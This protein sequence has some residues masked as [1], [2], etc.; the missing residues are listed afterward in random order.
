MGTKYNAGPFT[1]QARVYTNTFAPVANVTLYWTSTINGT[2]TQNSLPMEAFSSDSLWMATLPA[3]EAGTTVEYYV[4]GTDTLNNSSKATGNYTVTLDP[5]GVYDVVSARLEDEFISP[6]LGA[7]VEGT[8]TPVTV[9]LRNTGTNV[10]TNATIHWAV[11][12]IEQLPPVSW[13]NGNLPWDFTTPVTL[14]NYIP[15]LGIDEEIKV[16]IGELN[17]GAIAQD[18]ND[19]VK[20]SFYGC[21]WEMKGT[22]A[23][24]ASGD[25]TTW[26]EFTSTL[27]HCIPT[28]DITLE[29][30]SGTHNIAIDMT[31]ISDLM[32]GY[33]LT[34]TSQSSAVGGNATIEATSDVIKLSNSNNIVIKNLTI[35]ITGTTANTYGIRFTGNCDNVTIRDCRVTAITGSANAIYS[36]YNQNTVTGLTNNISIIHNEISGGTHGIYFYAGLN[37]STYGTNIVIDSN[38]VTDTYTAGIYLGWGYFNSISYNRV[39]SRDVIAAA[40]QGIS[41]YDCAAYKII[42]NHIFSA[43]TK[44]VGVTGLYF[45]NLNLITRTQNTAL[46]CNN[47]IS[48]YSTGTSPLS[49]AG[50]YIGAA[51]RAKVLNNSIYHDGNRTTVY[52][53]YVAAN[54]STLDI[55]YN[56][57]VMTSTGAST[58][59]IYLTGTALS[60]G[61]YI[62]YNNFQALTNVGYVLGT[63]RTTVEAWQ[64]AMT[65]DKNTFRILPT[66]PSVTTSL[67]QDNYAGF[68]APV[69]PEVTAD[70]EEINRGTVTNM[71]CY[72]G[73][74]VN[75]DAMLLDLTGWSTWHN[76][77]FVGQQEMLKA[78]IWN[79]G[80]TTLTDI[81]FYLEVGGAPAKLVSKTCNIP[82]NAIDTIDLDIITYNAADS[83]LSI[84]VYVDKLNQGTLTDV[85]NSNDTLER[86][87]Y[88]CSGGL[89]GLVKIG[90]GA[91][92]DY[93]TIADAIQRLTIC[94]ADS[95]VTFALE[96][97]A[98]A[99]PSINLTNIADYTNGYTLTI[100]SQ[101]E[102]TADVKIALPS[103][104]MANESG[105]TLNNSNNI[106]IKA[107]TIDMTPKTVACYGINFTGACT[108]VV[109]RD[110][111]FV[112]N[113]VAANTT[114][115]IYKASGSATGI[116]D[117][118]F[119]I[120]N[121]LLRG[122]NGINLYAGPST[123][124]YAYNI[125]VDSNMLESQRTL[126]IS[127]QYMNVSSV[128]A[129]TVLSKP[130]D[131]ITT[132]WTGMDIRYSKGDIIGNHVRMFEH[133]YTGAVMKGIYLSDYTG[134]STPEALIA[135]NEII[136]YGSASS[137]SAMS[138]G[139]DIRGASTVKIL[140]NSIYVSGL[141][142]S[143]FGNTGIYTYGSTVKIAAFKYNNIVMTHEKSRP[144]ELYT[145][146]DNLLPSSDVDYNNLYAPTYIYGINSG[147]HYYETI[148]EWRD[149]APDDLHSFRSLPVYPDTTAT[150]F[151][152]SLLQANYAG[153][154][155]PTSTD[156]LTDIDGNSRSTLT[157]IGC[158]HGSFPNVDAVLRDFYELKE[159]GSITGQQRPLKVIVFNNGVT[160][161]D[162]IE[163]K[164]E[165]NG[166]NTQT[167]TW[168]GNIPFAT[169]ETI[170]LGTVD[171]TTAGNMH[172][173]VYIANLGVNLEDE[174]TAN[175][176]IETDIVI[177]TAPI[178]GTK[179]IGSSASSDYNTIEE[180]L[181]NLTDC[182]ADGD[183]TFAFEEDTYY[184]ENINLS[185]I[186]AIMNN[187]TLTIT[188]KD[189]DATKVIIKRTSGSGVGFTLHN[190]N[191]IVIRD[192]TIDFSD[193]VGI[194][195]VNGIEF[196]G[197]CTNVVIRD[198]RIYTDPASTKPTVA[199]IRKNGSTGVVDNISI[200]YNELGGG[201]YGI[202]FEGGS[203]SNYGTNIVFDNNTLTNAYTDAAHFSFADFKSISANTFT[204]RATS[205]AFW[206][207]LLV[208]YCNGKIIGNRFGVHSNYANDFNVR[209][210]SLNA[211][212]NLATVPALIYNNE[213]LL[214]GSTTDGSYGII[215]N[216]GN[217]AKVLYNSICYKGNNGPHKGIFFFNTTGNQVELKYNNIV[218]EGGSAY[219]VY[220]EAT[221]PTYVGSLNI[222]YNNLYA[223][224]YVASIGGS[225]YTKIV[226]YQGVVTSD[227]HS[228]RINPYPVAPVTS[229][230]YP[231][232]DT[233][234]CPLSSSI[235]DDI[236]GWRRYSVTQMGAYTFMPEYLDIALWNVVNTNA[237]SGYSFDVVV[238]AENLG[239]T[240]IDTV[241]FKWSVDEE[242][243][244]NSL[245][246]TATPAM[247][248][249]ETRQINVGSF[250][251]D[252]TQ[253]IVSVWV[254]SVNNVPSFVKW[255]D[256]I[257]A[258]IKHAPLAWFTEPLV[259]D[260]V[261][262]L[263][264][265]VFAVIMENSGALTVQPNPEL[266]IETT[267]GTQTFY[268]TLPMTYSDGKWS[269]HIPP[270]YYGS[271]V[272][273]TLSVSDTNENT[274]ALTGATFIRFESGNASYT[275]KNLTITA[276]HGLDFSNT[277]CLPD[278]MDLHLEITNTGNGSYDFSQD[279]LTITLRVTQP[280][281][282]AVDTVIKTGEL[283][284][285][286]KLEILLVEHFPVAV[287]GQYDFVI[288][289][290]ITDD[291]L[292]YDNTLVYDYVSGRFGLPID[293]YFNVGQMNITFN[294]VAE[295]G[296][297][298]WRIIA[299]GIGRDSVVEPQVGDGIL[300]FNGSV[301]SLARLYTRQLDLSRTQTPSLSFWY[302]HDTL[303]CD[304]YTNVMVTVDGG[305]TYTLL[306]SVYKEDTAQ[307]W[308][309]YDVD[310]PLS[311]INQCVFIVFETMERD[312]SSQT[313]QYIDRIL[314][315]AKQDIAI[316]EFILPEL[317]SCDLENKEI[318]VVLTNLTDPVWDYS[319][320][321]ITLVLEIVETG[322]TFTH[323]L[324][325]DVLGSFASD[326][327]TLA[328]F[329]F[330]KGTHTLK[331]YF[332]ALFDK[333]K[334][335]DTI[336]ASIVINPALSVKV[337]PVSGNN[338]HC[339]AG[340]SDAFQSV[341]ITNTGN[342]DLSDIEL[343]LQI[344]TGDLNIAPYVTIVETYTDT[345][346]AGDSATYTFETSYTA[347]WST[348]YYAAVT[349]YLLC[350]SSHTNGKDEIVECVNTKDLSVVRIDNPTGTRDN[351]GSSIQVIAMLNNRSNQEGFTDANI[352]VLVTNSQG[353]QTAIIK[354]T[355]TVGVSTTVSH[356]F[357]SYT[358]PDDTIYYLT[359]YTD[360]YDDY[361]AND[362]IRIKRETN[363][364]GIET[365]GKD[366][367]TL[368]Q[369][370]P[371]PAA[372]ST[373]IDYSVPEAG[374]VVFHVRSV[375]GQLL[376]SQTI[377]VVSGKNSIAFNTD[378]LA[379][380]I[381]I[382]SIEY[383]GQRLVKRMSVQR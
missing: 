41:V 258:T 382:Y 303:P 245:L 75:G 244:P 364:V 326:T 20:A 29:F 254:D 208:R 2:P 126:G 249:N 179:Y 325:S 176:T 21:K 344:D 189:N 19:T 196:T 294:S 195:N 380:G 113:T 286:E 241:L 186:S 300:A 183:L 370:I 190:S 352:T 101:S 99:Y 15:T 132:T 150:G 255:N 317:S 270:Q 32:N 82:S 7:V 193:L 318:K 104:S 368:N 35:N 56:N 163:F 17:G 350:D 188:S 321:P 227:R 259:A 285:G 116:L 69:H 98:S 320:A 261:T 304:D 59:P 71:G 184:V 226:D 173:K 329:D 143:L 124:A 202:Y 26:N 240:D 376:Y 157:R 309:Q 383:K 338:T 220:L 62:D 378:T 125:Y 209:G 24:G 14:G 54:T 237:T 243:P 345:I 84:K 308:V 312:R 346:L 357:A 192:L 120:H 133:L 372:N 298:K 207:G 153:F 212:N 18:A 252:G 353:V 332:S 263:E 52:G 203:S 80:A 230:E 50:I 229:L 112:A 9:L 246:W 114:N 53:I 43:K 140:H 12:G 201:G 46:V 57:I 360:K 375:S 284:V 93:S 152:Q 271:K 160:V 225:N 108:N 339:L 293:E 311:A 42:G 97:S 92:N 351:V 154:E 166:G 162:T 10:L 136:V 100:T 129:N 122:S 127:L 145:P 87:T 111:R 72:H 156:I 222:D 280:V 117:S 135:N 138:S 119:I 30:V 167:Y 95:N 66:Y 313:W 239:M 48:L 366:G 36:I 194:E 200:I 340:E 354:E 262:S 172:I 182:G 4:L 371:N 131:A 3:F 283:L 242:Y 232:N 8:P 180:A 197:P 170:T 264:F 1:F 44:T 233:L 319:V 282:Y 330:T 228:Q 359:V 128:S 335:N 65:T 134:A 74:F 314:I 347:P 118:I 374:E 289:I 379:A 297:D 299:K 81:D 377:E 224:Q 94:G 247:T 178:S 310:L 155:M 290:D 164:W 158:Y 34:L 281:T 349:A 305:E 130:G 51:S 337:Q 86:E 217:K 83:Y 260:T 256:T 161:L 175:D 146:V 273:Y 16:W 49:P 78:V 315:T 214:K 257:T 238:E 216:G 174:I 204:S 89:K 68:I 269:A 279:S 5:N 115:L 266:Q 58:Y 103:T 67:M 365:L 77:V 139:L 39:T 165:I 234:Q 109:I 327:I 13:S 221:F 205:P 88:I 267:I 91:S 206:T 137:A 356:T 64:G 144:I 333:E 276:L 336:V 47:E 85:N 45:N 307:G 147:S 287:A 73:S 55:L 235:R 37:T 251:L 323:S 159:S 63:A 373:R 341:I 148:S 25:F 76:S 191:N 168:Y 79:K 110:C 23:F 231:K 250:V 367:F 348:T 210:M 331:A 215:F 151:P 60:S 363:N 141:G 28:G 301:G 316:T 278:A 236:E 291:H 187:H 381:Y 302:F 90:P 213:L 275:D 358:V 185:G 342:M 355:Q 322:Q 223:P 22:F 334:D 218:M 149:I 274:L 296:N 306:T 362:T 70:I 343:I 181:T 272:V 295:T 121:T 31:N 142:S 199:S 6:V 96:T 211:Q 361:P 27:Q 169:T 38:T 123:S 171:Y 40:W 107:I 106:V 288:D 328:N 253:A 219:P 248:L 268:N 292:A 277:D 198:C 265:D 324:T 105:I 33:T 102:D 11:N 177:C 369:N 61:W